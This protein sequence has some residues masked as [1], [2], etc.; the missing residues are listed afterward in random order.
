MNQNTQMNGLMQLMAAA[1]MGQGINP[2]I[3]K[4]G[5]GFTGSSGYQGKM[6]ENKEISST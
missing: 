1:M 5:P 4:G 6:K 3:H 2:K